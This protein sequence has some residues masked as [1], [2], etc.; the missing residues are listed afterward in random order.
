VRRRLSV[1][2]RP[3]ICGT[4]KYTNPTATSAPSTVTAARRW[5][6][7]N[8]GMGLIAAAAIWYLMARDL[9]RIVGIFGMEP[10]PY[11]AR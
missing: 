10:P 3:A 9:Y 11:Q 1:G 2:P 7:K 6:V 5:R 4:T 8:R